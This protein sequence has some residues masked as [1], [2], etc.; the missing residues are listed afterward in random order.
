[1]RQDVGD[2]LG[3][4]AID[5]DDLNG[6]FAAAIDTGQAI[7]DGVPNLLG[8]LRPEDMINLDT[9]RVGSIND[10]ARAFDVI[11]NLLACSDLAG[12]L[13][14]LRGKHNMLAL[15][16]QANSPWVPIGTTTGV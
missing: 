1:M 2:R 7:G 14:I 15:A 13:A 16:W 8:Q 12:R 10:Q 9:R 6:R 4:L 3:S 5:L 11:N